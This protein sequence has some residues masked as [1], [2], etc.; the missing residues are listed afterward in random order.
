MWSS[1]NA[2]RVRNGEGEVCSE[3]YR[4]QSSLTDEHCLR[5]TVFEGGLGDG[6]RSCE[7]MVEYALAEVV[8]S[9]GRTTK[10]RAAC[11]S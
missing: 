4:G 6:S 11:L 7:A 10:G 5:Q 1:K 8:E 3:I 2:G 9:P